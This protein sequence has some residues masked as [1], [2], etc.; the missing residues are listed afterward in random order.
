MEEETARDVKLHR[1]ARLWGK[2]KK[3]EDNKKL[4]GGR[5]NTQAGILIQPNRFS[6]S[7]KK[8]RKKEEIA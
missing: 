3:G 6:S 5:K 4:W 8:K 2:R 7:L 1:A